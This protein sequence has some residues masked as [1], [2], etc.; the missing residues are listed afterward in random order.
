MSDNEQALIIKPIQIE[1]L[2]I[3]EDTSLPTSPIEEAPENILS[4]LKIAVKLSTEAIGTTEEEVPDK[5]LQVL[6]KRIKQQLI[7]ESITSKTLPTVRKMIN[8]QESIQQI[9]SKASNIKLKE[10]NIEQKKLIIV[11]KEIPKKKDK[12]KKKVLISKKTTKIQEEIQTHKSKSLSRDEEVS[13]YKNKY[14]TTLEVIT[15]S[16]NFEIE[17]ENTLPDSYY[18]ESIEK[19]STA[20]DKNTPLKFVEKLGVVNV[21]DKYESNFTIPE[22]IEVAKE[23]IVTIPTATIKTK[24]IE[25][26]KFVNTIE[27]IEV[28]EEFETLEANK[29]LE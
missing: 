28:S 19:T 16:E 18:F 8:Q 5:V 3:S 21:S 29:Y 27:V 4:K 12:V 2:N 14:A 15:V 1:T 13:Q 6:E 9:S 10:I 11:K 26:L 7:E 22:K 20:N 25:N 17:E 24:E 23:G